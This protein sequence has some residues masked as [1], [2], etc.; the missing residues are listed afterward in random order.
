M[1]A[2]R[3]LLVDQGLSRSREWGPVLET[4]GHGLTRVADLPDVAGLVTESYDL[5]VVHAPSAGESLS[6]FLS[7]L[8]AEEE[9][10]D[11]VVVMDTPDAARA[12]A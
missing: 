6:P 1:A 2:C 12:V 3:V 4:K 7:V 5:V 9:A 11:V 10:P 8:A